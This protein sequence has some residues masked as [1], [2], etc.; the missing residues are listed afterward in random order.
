[1][2]DII[3][4]PIT[5]GYNLAKFNANFNTIQDVINNQVL[6]NT[7]GNNTMHQQLD[8][9]SNKIIN[10]FVDV[11]DP[12]S[13]LTVGAADTRYYNVSGDTLLG[14]MDAN[15]Q[16]IIS[17]PLP[18]TSTEPVRNGEYQASK[19]SAVRAPDG[20]VITPLPPAGSRANKVMGFDALGNP[21]GTLPLSGSGTELAIDLANSVDAFKGAAMV[22]W[23]RSAQLATDARVATKLNS[24]KID[25]WEYAYLVT[26]KPTPAN[27]STWDWTPAF[28]A[29]MAAFPTGGGTLTM[30]V[31]GTYLASRI[32]LRRFVVIDGGNVA[33]TVLK[34]IG[35]TNADFIVSENFA[36]LT[37]TGAIVSAGTVPSWFGLKDIRVDGNKAGGNTAGRLIAWYGP[38]QMMIGTVH[39]SNCGNASEAVWTEDSNTASALPFTAQEE[40]Q[41][42]KVFIMD[43]AGIGWRCRGPHNSNAEVI[44]CGRNGG[45][46]L[47]TETGTGYGSGFDWIGMLHT[48]AN[49]SASV[50]ASDEGCILGGIARI[51]VLVT[52]G[53]NCTITADRVQINT[54]RCFNMC[55]VRDGLIVNGN[56]VTI[57]NMSGNVWTSSGDHV[58]V[59]INGNY[60]KCNGMNISGANVTADGLVVN[61]A[62]AQITGIELSNYI[63]AGKTAITLQG[64]K[65]F[66]QGDLS[67]NARSFKYTAGQNNRVV[68]EIASNAGQVP[69]VGDGPGTTDRFDL[70]ASGTGAGATRNRGL[71]SPTF[72]INV[73]QQDVVIPHG[74]LYTPPRQNVTF[75]T[76]PATPTGPYSIGYAQVTST[77]ATNITVSVTISTL[78]S[79]GLV[80]R[81]ALTVDC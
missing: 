7:G 46:G 48:Y 59:T 23:S 11:D 39:L 70:R 16:R 60:F 55:G 50:P 80:G 56:N 18:V 31:G 34:Q 58:A 63:G 71:L 54:Y 73:A 36:T 8:M 25:I 49:G 17:L 72:P 62:F 15:N 35:G 26:S 28:A 76:F 47:V 61:G 42:G 67:N 13:L 2:S 10:I 53:D 43:N 64:N 81:L 3:L 21:L 33:S 14:T 38:A 44:V 51:G 6:H 69:V 22:G 19:L 40:G 24:T 37:G 45:F 66:L 77:D 9:N 57:D 5:S 32:T 12:T 52:D 74:L 75:N 20:E 78:G 27:P 4:A 29:A 41:F 79:A 68:L 30:G 1:M 65:N